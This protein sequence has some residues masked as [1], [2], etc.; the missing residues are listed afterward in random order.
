MCVTDQI[1]FYGLL[2]KHYYFVSDRLFF[3]KTK[4]TWKLV[5]FVWAVSWEVQLSF[6]FYFSSQGN[7]IWSTKFSVAVDFS[8]CY[9]RTKG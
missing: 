7:T 8:S 3:P 4:F 6:S 1:I 5:A 9:L 2:T